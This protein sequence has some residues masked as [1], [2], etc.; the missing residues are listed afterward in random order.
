LWLLLTFLFNAKAQK[1][2]EQASRLLFRASRPKPIADGRSPQSDV[3]NLSNARRHN[4]A[5]R[6]I[7]QAGGLFHPHQLIVH[8]SF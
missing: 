5:G 7:E 8:F 2:V 3:E 1:R 6:R 4:S